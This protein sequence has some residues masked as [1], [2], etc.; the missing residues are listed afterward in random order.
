MGEICLKNIFKQFCQKSPKRGASIVSINKAEKNALFF[1]TT[2]EV[3]ML[4]NIINSAVK[5]TKGSFVSFVMCF[6]L[7]NSTTVYSADAC[8]WVQIEKSKIN[9]AKVNYAL[10][11]PGTWMSVLGCM[12]TATSGSHVKYKQEKFLQAAY[13]SPVDLI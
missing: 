9:R 7:L 11:Y 5:K 10:E 13:P 4:E 6:L 12:A 3:N 1:K 8:Q 2:G